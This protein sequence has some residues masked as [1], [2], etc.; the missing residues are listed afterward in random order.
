MNA[1]L[2]DRRLI[3]QEQH[4]NSFGITIEHT[5]NKF[6]LKVRE[7]RRRIDRPTAGQRMLVYPETTSIN[8]L[9][10]CYHDPIPVVEEPPPPSL[11]D[12][13]FSSLLICF[14][15]DRYRILLACR[16]HPLR[17]QAQ[18]KQT[19]LLYNCQT[20]TARI[21]C[22]VYRP[23]TRLVVKTTIKRLPRTSQTSESQQVTPMT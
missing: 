10:S 16:I 14:R 4:T 1:T 13:R 6:V 21:S 12:T 20:P 19:A 11:N 7:N 2:A 9:Y 17:P 5:C 3:R 8:A 22:M 23:A 15:H 18:Y